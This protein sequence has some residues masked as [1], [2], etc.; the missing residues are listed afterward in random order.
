MS[1]SAETLEPIAATSLQSPGRHIPTITPESSRPLGH[2]PLSP[3]RPTSGRGPF[4]PRAPMYDKKTCDMINA[5]LERGPEGVRDFYRWAARQPIRWDI[6][7]PSREAA[8]KKMKRFLH[9]RIR[10]GISCGAV[11]ISQNDDGTWD[12]IESPIYR[13]KPE[14]T[15]G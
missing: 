12:V 6:G 9:G 7:L 5:M 3:W 4:Y 15:E 11:Y 14:I 8:E 1:R 10:S 2:G 13:H